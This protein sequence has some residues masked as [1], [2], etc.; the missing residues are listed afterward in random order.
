[1]PVL[2][3]IMHNEV[4]AMKKVGV[5]KLNSFLE[6]GSTEIKVIRESAACAVT[7]QVAESQMFLA[8]CLRD[9]DIFMTIFKLLIMVENQVVESCSPQRVL[10]FV[11]WAQMVL[12][13]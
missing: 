9:K 4:A 11:T 6:T 10:C 13:K 8:H 1:M 2:L 5:E 3:R 12:S 7:H